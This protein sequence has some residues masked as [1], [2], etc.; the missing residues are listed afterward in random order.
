MAG[1]AFVQ[2]QAEIGDV[3]ENERTARFIA[4]STREDR[5]GDIIEQS[6][7]LNDF[8][9][10]PTFLW[11]HQSFS[12]PIGWVREFTPNNEQTLT[13][14]RVEFLP[15]GEDEFVDKLVRLT[16]MKAIRAVSVGFVPLEAEERFDNDHHFMGY[17]FLRSQLIELSLCTVPANPDAVSLA[18][19]LDSSPYFLRRVCADP[20]FIRSG[21][22]PPAAASPKDIGRFVR[23]K[24]AIEMLERLKAAHR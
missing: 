18:R 5:Y 17:R 6:W 22:L 9:K 7:D 3:N 16:Q 14:A 12:T 24:V 23:R 8:W 19:S 10:N 15:R 11:G 4:S 1:L 2:K 13:R 21:S 20:E